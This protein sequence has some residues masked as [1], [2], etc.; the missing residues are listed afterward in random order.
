MRGRVP[1]AELAYRSCI[2]TAMKAWVRGLRDRPWWQE[3]L[4]IWL[5]FTVVVLIGSLADGLVFGL[6]SM[7]PRSVFDPPTEALLLAV[8]FTAVR[9]LTRNGRNEPDRVHR[10]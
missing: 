7:L 10:Q 4:L 1:A 2:M 9:R 3:L 6:P 5:L 8:P